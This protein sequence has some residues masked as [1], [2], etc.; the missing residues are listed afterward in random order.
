MKEEFYA[1]VKGG[2]S[3]CVG[4]DAKELTLEQGD[5]EHQTG[6]VDNFID[7]HCSQESVV[8]GEHDGGGPVRLGV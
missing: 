6:P 5:V 1:S 2:A 8:R 3:L 4:R 7:Y